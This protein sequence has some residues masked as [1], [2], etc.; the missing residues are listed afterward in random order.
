MAAAQTGVVVRIW[1][2]P[3]ICCFQRRP[4]LSLA[5]DLTVLLLF[6]PPLARQRPPTRPS[7]SC[8]PA[9]GALDC[10]SIK[11]PGL[12]FPSSGQQP[13]AASNLPQQRTRSRSAP[14]ATLA[15]P[16]LIVPTTRV[17]SASVLSAAHRNTLGPTGFRLCSLDLLFVPVLDHSRQPVRVRSLLI[18]RKKQQQ[19]QHQRFNSHAIGRQPLQSL[20][21]SWLASAP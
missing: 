21:L 4:R 3:I 1:Q 2:L 7:P 11:P 9:T 20:A 19:Q 18:R 6:H 5:A 10:P 15:I 14:L 8:P 17:R 12:H 16:I 13:A